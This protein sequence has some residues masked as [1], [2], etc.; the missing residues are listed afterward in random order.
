MALSQCTPSDIED[1]AK[2]KKV[3]T[4]F[5]ILDDMTR[6]VAGD[7]IE[8]VSITKPGA[9]IHDYEVTPHDLVN[10]YDA[11][12]VLSNGLGL[13]RWLEKFLQHAKKA[14]HV[15]LTD[16]I[17][18]ISIVEG[19]YVDKPNP[20]AWMSPSNAKIYIR[21]IQKA[22]SELVPDKAQEFEK[23]AND[24]IQALD[25][26]D[27]QFRE[28]IQQVPESKRWL[29]TSEGAFT[30]LAKDYGIKELYLWPVNADEEGTPQQVKKVIDE[31]RIHQIPVTF[32]ESTISDKA[33]KQVA[34]ESG[35]K[36]AGVLYVDSLTSSTGEAPTYL[37]LL[38]MNVKRII[39]A[40]QEAAVS[41]P[42]HD[43]DTR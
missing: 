17:E 39:E 36:Y 37:K 26:L 14:K 41:H 25:H 32:S 8:V 27:Q 20:H 11:D 4:T 16:G 1:P 3:L 7:D 9:E 10:A 5:T 42:S 35:A 21:N 30:Y 29:V 19:P 2:K 24:Y 15:E 12:V 28:K 22:L 31:I 43:S 38:E 33:M 18:P 34:Q 13:E 6:M 40:F 23:R